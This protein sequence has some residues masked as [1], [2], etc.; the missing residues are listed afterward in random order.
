M[1]AVVRFCYGCKTVSAKE[2]PYA[3]A[4]RFLCVTCV[5][6]GEGNVV[7]FASGKRTLSP[8][9]RDSRAVSRGKE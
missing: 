5:N 6:G 8:D 3:D 1:S 7:P 4:I 2:G 9:E